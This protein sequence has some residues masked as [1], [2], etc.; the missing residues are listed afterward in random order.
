[1]GE[2]QVVVAAKW[3]ALSLLGVGDQ[4]KRLWS[5]TGE[6]EYERGNRP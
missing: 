1:M 3:D 5:R 6:R 4:V 2:L